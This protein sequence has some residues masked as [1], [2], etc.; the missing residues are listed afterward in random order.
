MAE[1][2]APERLAQ[3]R[4]A[5][6]SIVTPALHPGTAAGH[7]R[8]LLAEVDRLTAER[9]EVEN[10]CADYADSCESGAELPGV[11]ASMW[12]RVR[13]LE[14]LLA[15]RYV[16]RDAARADLSA[17]REKAEQSE[18]LCRGYLAE[19]GRLH[20]MRQR[21]L[22]LC[23]WL[24]GGQWPGD[25]ADQFAE[26]ACPDAQREVGV[27]VWYCARCTRLPQLARHIR[28]ALHEDDKRAAVDGP[29]EQAQ[30]GPDKPT[31]D[32]CPECGD[33]HAGPELAGICVGCP[34]P[35]RTYVPGMY[36]PPT[37]APGTPASPSG[38]GDWDDE[39]TVCE[40]GHVEDEHEEFGFQ[41]CTAEVCEDRQ[42]GMDPAAELVTYDCPCVAFD[43]V[44]DEVAEP[45]ADT[46]T[47]PGSQAC[48]PCGLPTMPTAGEVPADWP[49][50]E[51][52]PLADAK[53]VTGGG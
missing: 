44:G 13:Q 51:A 8:D 30:D 41:S 22:D 2:L 14:G 1:P 6:A 19:I 18:A 17:A 34:C 23:M 47:C 21:V 20:A 27:P 38:A 33:E 50:D 52:D 3:I 26:C 42:L 53:E 40:C 48:V 49:L 4:A 43:P 32:A 10:A 36:I 7:R 5:D 16:E 39:P 11:V 24:D 9:H 28:A 12:D 25:E 29:P 37:A 35:A 46:C 15:A 45:S 31:D